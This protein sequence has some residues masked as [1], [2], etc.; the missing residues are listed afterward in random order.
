MVE[1]GVRGIVRTGL[2]LRRRVAGAGGR[3]SPPAGRGGSPGDRGGWAARCADFLQRSGRRVAALG[4]LAVLGSVASAHAQVVST[5]VWPAPDYTRL[6]LESKSALAYTMFSVKDPGRLVLD[7]QTDELTPALLELHGKVSEEDPH[8]KGLR[9]AWNRPGVVRVVLDL[10][11]DVLPQV[12]TLKPIGEYGHRLVLDVYPVVPHDPLAKLIEETEKKRAA[13]GSQPAVMRLATVV[14]DA[15]HGGEDPGA[16][17]RRGSR[18]KDVTLSIAR[19]LKALI[20]AEPDMRALLTRDGDYYLPLQARVDKAR[21]V[22][23]D[24]F[25]SIHADAFVR[26]HARGSSVFALSERRAT[27]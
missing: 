5:R 2:G 4:A 14:I 3:S 11:T 7:L 8:L 6:T 21:R 19:R 20:D 1:R 9:V 24:L 13:Q 26:P 23:A 15:G 12:F 25:V 27:S 16:I 18:E 22:R 10:K 17:G